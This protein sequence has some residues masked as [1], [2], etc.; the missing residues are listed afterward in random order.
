M[1][2]RRLSIM[3]IRYGRTGPRLAGRF[4]YLTFLYC[5]TRCPF[6]RTRAGHLYGRAWRY[7]GG[8]GATNTL[9][10]CR[11]LC[12]V[13]MVLYFTFIGSRASVRA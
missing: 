10:R 2:S 4:S 3:D 6:V 1:L 5:V 13:G 8:L 12:P 11:G 9:S 7:R